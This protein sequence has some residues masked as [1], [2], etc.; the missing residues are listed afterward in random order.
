M[1]D[2]TVILTMVD[3]SHAKPGSMLEVLLQSF[4]TGQGTQRLL[5]HLVIITMDP[6]AFEY[7]RFLHPH[8][9]HPSTFEH[10]FATKRQSLQIPDHNVFSWRRNNVLIEVIEL[11]YN[12]IFTDT[13]VLWLKSP[14]QNFHPIH[15]LS[16][17]CNFSSNEERAYSIQEGGI[18]FMK[19][20]AIALEFLKH[21]KLSK[22]LYPT[23]NVEES[24]CATILHN[25]DLVEMY[26]FRVHRVDT[27]HFG[28]FCQLNNDILEK[29]YTIH[30]NCCDDLTSKVHDLRI[31]LDDWFRFRE[32]VKN[33]NATEKMALRWPQ[34]CTG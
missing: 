21:W 2:R 7:C 20:N 29:A 6:Q 8:C 16:I 22:I 18:F 26:G 32:H 28:G 12:I 9:I 3:E 33:N 34:K 17:S 11:G 31:V 4:K 15:E 13:D 23:T 30:A 5:N 14:L 25:E 1:P 10:Y 19:A 24:L 27:D